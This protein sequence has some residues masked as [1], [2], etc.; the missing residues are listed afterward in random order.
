MQGLYCS[1]KVRYRICFPEC[2][3][4]YGPQGLVSQLLQVVRGKREG[5][6][7]SLIYTIAWEMNVRGALSH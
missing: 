4:W 3:S 7:F 6:Y 2:C 1:A 5:R